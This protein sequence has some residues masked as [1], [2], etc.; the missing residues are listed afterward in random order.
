MFHRLLFILEHQFIESEFYPTY[1]KLL[2]NQWKPYD[3]LRDNQERQLMNLLQFVYNKVPYYQK[4]F[5]EL[6][7]KPKDIKNLE[8]CFCGSFQND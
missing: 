3:E 8:E 5:D 1:K 7:L 6:H 4:L 2:V